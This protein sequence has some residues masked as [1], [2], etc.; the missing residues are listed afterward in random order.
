MVNLGTYILGVSLAID[1]KASR[2][3]KVVAFGI[4]VSEKQVNKKTTVVKE[5]HYFHG[6][7]YF[8]TFADGME[9]L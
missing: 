4:F 7:L 3:I 9:C 8:S 1:V 2:N 5:R 6:T